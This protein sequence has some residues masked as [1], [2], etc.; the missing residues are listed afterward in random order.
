MRANGVPEKV[1]MARAV[2]TRR[3]WMRSMAAVR[4]R[5]SC[6]NIV[7]QEHRAIKRVTK[8]MLNF[9]LFRAAANVLAGV[10]LMLMLMIRKGQF[11]REGCNELSFAEQFLH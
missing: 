6:G 2:P 3:S 8:P 11:L 5:S 1:M 9:K 7:E 4:H 10:E